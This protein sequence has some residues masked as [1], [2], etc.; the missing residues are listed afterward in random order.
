MLEYTFQVLQDKTNWSNITVVALSL[1]D[2]ETL[3][4][5]RVCEVIKQNQINPII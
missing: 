2:E 1:V 4:Y 5:E 3:S